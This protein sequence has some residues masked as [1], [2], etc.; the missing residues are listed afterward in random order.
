MRDISATDKTLMQFAVSSLV[1]LPYILIFDGA[2]ELRAEGGTFLCLLLLGVIHTGVAYV[3]YFGAAGR[4]KS[5]T[6]AI[7]S[8]IDPVVSI[9]VS[10]IFFDERLGAFGIVGATLIVGSAILC[11]IDFPK[12]EK[13]RKN[14][15]LPENVNNSEE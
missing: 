10:V 11:E 2:L 9:L 7:L 5:V 13:H 12:T 15:N 4:L 8:Y 6:V 1:L 3:L 14:I